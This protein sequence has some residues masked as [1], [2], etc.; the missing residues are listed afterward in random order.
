LLLFHATTLKNSHKIT[1]FAGNSAEILGIRLAG[2]LDRIF[3]D[4]HVK[5]AGVTLSPPPPAGQTQD[6]TAVA[7]ELKVLPDLIGEQVVV[8]GRVYGL[9]DFG[10]MTLVNLGAAYP[11]QLAT[12][13]LKGDAKTI[14]SKID[15]KTLRVT[16]IVIAY[17]GKPEI[18]ITNADQLL[19]IH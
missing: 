10:S 13:V 9:K 15:G 7:V 3:K 17:K 1:Q 6:S 14:T 5:I 16:G 8:L 2:A 18:V 12:L 19:G 4:Q 11:D